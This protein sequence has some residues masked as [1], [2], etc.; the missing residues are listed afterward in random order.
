MRIKI[1]NT[2][3]LTLGIVGVVFI[4]IWGPPQPQLELGISIGL[5]DAT[6]I[7]NS[8]KTVAEYNK[9]V[10]GLYCSK[11]KFIGNNYGLLECPICDTS[12]ELISIN[13]ECPRGKQKNSED[14][15][16]SWLKKRKQAILEIPDNNLQRTL[17][18]LHNE[19]FENYVIWKRK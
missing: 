9:E 8:G 4:F 5:E 17:L 7:D 13:L 2:I 6:P 16:F 3:G 15:F 19:Y 1:V 18:D 14:K 11:C 10:K 12:L